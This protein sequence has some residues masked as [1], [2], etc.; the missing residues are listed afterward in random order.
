[1]VP[2]RLVTFVPTLSV[3]YFLDFQMPGTLLHI[4]WDCLQIK[5]YLEGSLPNSIYLARQGYVQITKGGFTEP[6]MTG[7]YY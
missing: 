2:Q 6:K 4:W 5:H 3:K 7:L 1:M